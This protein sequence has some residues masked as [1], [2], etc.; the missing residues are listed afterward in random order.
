[1]S[2][3]N[4]KVRHAPDFAF[5][6]DDLIL[7]SGSSVSMPNRPVASSVSRQTLLIKPNN[8]ANKNGIVRG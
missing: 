5:Y 1:M 3:R 6:T 4:F 8:A 7:C 2:N